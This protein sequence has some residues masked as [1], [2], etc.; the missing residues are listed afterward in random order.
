MRGFFSNHTSLKKLLVIPCAVA[1]FFM[2]GFRCAADVDADA[3]L[4]SMHKADIASAVQEKGERP[5]NQ[6]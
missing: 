4:D 2:Y 6:D 3:R 1:L 5:D